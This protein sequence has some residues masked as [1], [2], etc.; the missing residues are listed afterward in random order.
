MVDWSD[1]EREWAGV[2]RNGKQLTLPAY[3]I[4]GIDP[5]TGRR[6]E[7][8][9]PE[10][11]DAEAAESEVDG[12]HRLADRFAEPHARTYF[13]GAANGL[14]K[15][16]FSTNVDER[17]QALRAGSPVPLT[18]MATAQGGRLRETAYHYQF[19]SWRRHGEWF[20]HCAEIAAEISRLNA[21]SPLVDLMKPR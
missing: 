17:L 21:P 12:L 4:Y 19:A 8:I 16:G 20:D 5:N 13:I 10:G 15:I 9:I 11:T 3:S 1:A 6:R 2:D 14:V 18:L 7:L